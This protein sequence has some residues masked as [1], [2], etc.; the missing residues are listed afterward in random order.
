MWDSAQDT[1]CCRPPFCCPRFWVIFDGSQRESIHSAFLG[2]WG[3]SWLAAVGVMIAKMRIV[4]S[5]A[6]RRRWC[7]LMFAY[8][9]LV[10][11]SPSTC[12]SPFFGFSGLVF[13]FLLLEIII[14]M[15]LLDPHN[16][17]N[18]NDNLIITLYDPSVIVVIGNNSDYHNNN[19][20][21]NDDNNNSSSSSSSSR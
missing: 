14:I 17:K 10:C 16:S 9:C 8:V 19:Y 5:L 3:K 2:R 6:L 11:L 12:S 20:N 4:L 13:V 18:N 7:F 1:S 21:N 15:F